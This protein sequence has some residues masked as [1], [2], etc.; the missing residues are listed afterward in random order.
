MCKAG[1]PYCYDKNYSKTELK[2][3][4]EKR[5]NKIN[6]KLENAEDPNSEDLDD[7][8]TAR[9]YAHKCINEGNN[10][11]VD[12]NNSVESAFATLEKPDGGGT[13]NPYTKESP[14]TGFC[15]SPYPEH[16]KVI[17]DDLSLSEFEA[18]CSEHK[19]LLEKEDHYIGTWHDPNTGTKYLDIS[20]NTQDA[21]VAREQCKQ[22]DQI[23]YFDLQDFSSVE[24]DA[25]ATSGQH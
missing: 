4:A 21:K 18:Y 14:I 3:I 20:I 19:E 15:Y 2:R 6:Q 13:F 23:A 9:A 25:N 5:L 16:S 11:N 7:L 22:K 8:R 17:K 24:V 1:G 10:I 12:E